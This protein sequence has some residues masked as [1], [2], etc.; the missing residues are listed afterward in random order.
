MVTVPLLQA[1]AVCWCLHFSS[2][3]GHGRPAE[4]VLDAIAGFFSSSWIAKQKYLDVTRLVSYLQ[5][6]DIYQGNI[7]RR[8]WLLIIWPQG[9]SSIPAMDGVVCIMLLFSWGYHP[10][11]KNPL[12]VPVLLMLEKRPAIV[13]MVINPCL[14]RPCSRSLRASVPWT[15]PG[16]W[17]PAKNTILNRGMTWCKIWRL[18]PSM[19]INVL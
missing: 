7:L 2:E 1:S 10:P 19:I 6:G 18:I 14:I 9:S 13:P 17:V 8:M 4:I 12:V 11:N 15:H 5:M 3:L 16:C